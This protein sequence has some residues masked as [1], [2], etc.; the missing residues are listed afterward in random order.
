MDMKSTTPPLL[1][2][3]ESPVDTKKEQGKGQPA[4]YKPPSSSLSAP[5]HDYEKKPTS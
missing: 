5:V 3:K 1:D 4:L 2:V